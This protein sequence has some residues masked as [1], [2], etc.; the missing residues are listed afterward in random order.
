MKELIKKYVLQNSVKFDGKPNAGNIIGKIIGEKPE[1]K[2]DIKEIQAEIQKKIKDISK[3]SVEEQLKEL[4]KIAP[5]LLEK[6]EQ[7]KK[8]LPELKNAEKGKVIMRFEPSIS[9]PLHIGHAYVL[10]LIHAYVK[11]YDGKLILRLADTNADNIYEPA[12]ELI[13]EDAQWLTDNGISE[14]VIQSENMEK[15]YAY[16]EKLLR[17]G[18]AY[19]CTC[20][21]EK[22]KS[23]VDEKKECPC[24]NLSHEEEMERWQ[25]MLTEYKEGNAVLRI[26]TDVKHKNPAMR[27][28]PAMRVKEAKHPRQGNLYRVW[29]LMNFSVAVDDIESG[30]THIIRGKDHADNA[31]RQEY[32]YKYLN[33]EIPQTVFV[34]RINFEGLEVSCSKTRF[35]I[36]AGTFECWEDIRLPFLRALRQRGYTPECFINYAID[37]GPSKNDKTVCCDEFFKQINAYNKDIID[38]VSDRHFFV[39][40]PVKIKINNAPEKTVKLLKHPDNPRRGKRTFKTDDKFLITKEDFASIKEGELVLLMDCLNFIKKGK[41]L[42]FDSEEYEIFRKRGKKIIHWLPQENFLDAVVRMPD[43]SVVKGKLEKAEINDGE[44]VQFERFGFVKRNESEF[45]FG[46]R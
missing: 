28:W 44:I 17:T 7:E 29:P 8:Q 39:A 36:E 27:D 35:K 3:L 23:F 4:K 15:Y 18:K 37:V 25:K 42:V 11:K 32:I 22:F 20:T 1:L 24:R 46:H 43:N 38:P 21:S 6:K 10:G 31:K 30:M 16:A 34:G 40:D 2:K 9:G 14:V 5:E 41:D 19:V 26:K 33:K 13:P 45:W 12:Y